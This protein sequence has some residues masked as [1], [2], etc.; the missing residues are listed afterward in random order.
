MIVRIVTES[1]RRLIIEIDGFLPER[2]AEVQD[3]VLLEFTPKE[4]VSEYFPAF[5]YTA[6]RFTLVAENALEFFELVETSYPVTVSDVT[7]TASVIWR[8]F[9]T[10]YVAQE[11]I[12][13]TPYPFFVECLGF[14]NFWKNESV[15]TDSCA[16]VFNIGLGGEFDVSTE[17]DALSVQGWGFHSRFFD[18]KE[19][20]A[21]AV[22][23]SLFATYFQSGET[24]FLYT[25]RAAAQP[26]TGEQAFDAALLTFEPPISTLSVNYSD[27]DYRLLS[28]DTWS[29]SSVFTGDIPEE[30]GTNFNAAVQSCRFR[31][32]TNGQLTL[33]VSPKDYLTR[34]LIFNEFLWEND[35]FLE[36]EYAPLRGRVYLKAIYSNSPFADTV[37]FYNFDTR[38]WQDTDSARF[39][40]PAT[41]SLSIT[42]DLEE[43]TFFK[44]VRFEVGFITTPAPSGDGTVNYFAVTDPD[45]GN[46]YPEPILVAAEYA[47]AKV[48]IALKSKTNAAEISRTLATNLYSQAL[49]VEPAFYFGQVS[50]NPRL[51]RLNF[52]V[53]VSLGTDEQLLRDYLISKITE[54][55]ASMSVLMNTTFRRQAQSV[56]LAPFEYYAYDY[57]RGIKPFRL[58]RGS[59]DLQR[60]LISGDF[61]EIKM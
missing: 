21:L 7:A 30:V 4:G 41:E 51:D 8:G 50:A 33:T 12:Q 2:E 10:P 27:A 1:G 3:G 15:G 22:A 52:V 24:H 32:Q 17:L 20:V 45:T 57:G 36:T 55:Y 25:H 14:M 60:E 34:L 39:F 29:I 40:S 49:T 58:V 44:I 48:A 47:F 53:P 13:A 9:T 28:F 61:I 46:P 5:L 19:G 23:N 18:N 56:F 42:I 31:Q 6:L 11:P 54:Q 26:L 37:R 38:A 35:F 16:D 43:F 59:Y